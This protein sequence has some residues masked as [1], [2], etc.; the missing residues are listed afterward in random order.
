[1]IVLKVIWKL[2]RV[3]V[4]L[5]IYAIL[6]FIEWI[7]NLAQLL[8]GWV[9]RFLGLLM[10]ATAVVCWAMRLDTA[11]E[12]IRMLVAG[13]TV[14]LLPIVGDFIVAGIILLQ[15]PIKQAIKN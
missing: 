13:V 1:M 6:K 11:P 8:S 5:P 12:I 2:V 14:F 4:L 15:F 7:C 3:S 10:L 9:F